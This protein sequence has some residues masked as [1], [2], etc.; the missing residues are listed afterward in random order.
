MKIFILGA[1][2]FLGHYVL[3]HLVQENHKITILK[4]ST[5]KE[6]FSASIEICEGDARSPGKW[7]EKLADMDAIINLAG[8]NIAQTWTKELKKEIYQSR[9]LATQNIVAALPK[10]PDQS[11]ILINASA[12]GYY[13]FCGDEWCTEL[14]AAGKDFLATVCQDW[15]AAAHEAEHKGIRVVIPRIG[16][17]LGHGG[18]LEKMVKMFRRFLGSQI[19]TGRQWFSWVH[20]QDVLKFIEFSLQNRFQG[21]YNLCSP[22]PVQN[23]TLTKIL[24]NTLGVSVLLRAPTFALKLALGEFSNVV[25]EGQRVLPQRLIDAKFPFQFLDLETALKNLQL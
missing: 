10:S 25:L 19:G 7:Q 5:N 16:V 20:I 3:A 21:V 14:S 9:V 24:A 4:R 1:T 6:Q 22:N 11:Q 15:E 13:G 12:I 23:H 17:V 18:A 8:C 2:G